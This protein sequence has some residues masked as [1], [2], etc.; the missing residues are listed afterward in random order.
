[1][2]EDPKP[3]ILKS[4]ACAFRGVKEAFLSERNVR[5]HFA[6]ATLAIILGFCL[7]ISSVEWLFLCVVI[8]V[9]LITEFINTA[10]EKILDLVYKGQNGKVRFIKDVFAGVVLIAAISSLVIGGII[11]L[12][13]IFQLF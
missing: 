13:K 10:V 8:S 1:M 9:V 11:F 7:K 6:L 5:I 4:F 2:E 12:P 3:T